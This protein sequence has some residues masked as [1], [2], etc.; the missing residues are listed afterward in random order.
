[1]IETVQF[2]SGWQ[3]RRSETRQWYQFTEDLIGIDKHLWNCYACHRTF[4]LEQFKQTDVIVEVFRC[5]CGE[6]ISATP[7]NECGPHAYMCSSCESIVAVS[8]EGVL[9]QP[10]DIL[11]MQ[12]HSAL[13][14][15]AVAIGTELLVAEAASDR[16]LAPVRLMRD[17][18]R[19]EREPFRSPELSVHRCLILTCKQPNVIGGYLLWTD[20]DG[21]A[22]LRQIYVMPSL[23]RRGFAAALV[24]HWI[25][26][27][28]DKIGA[29]FA[30]EAPNHKSRN[31]LLKLGLLNLSSPDLSKCYSVVE[32]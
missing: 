25:S 28:A 9:R 11:R 16:D 22:T 18:A 19:Q 4:S 24:H 23:R 32:M 2:V 14:E 7:S 3:A 31:L 10:D 6:E 5:R 13:S 12:L 20:D 15:R 21:E 17:F 29:R 8:F 1:M 26:V 27:Y 30:I